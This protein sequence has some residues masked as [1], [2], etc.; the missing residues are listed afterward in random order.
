MVHMFFVPVR[1]GGSESF[2]YGGAEFFHD[3]LFHTM[4]INIH[5]Y[6]WMVC[7]LLALTSS[8]PVMFALF[9]PL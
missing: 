5:S 6:M 9:G 8:C 7:G 3:Y 4:H 1:I 2:L